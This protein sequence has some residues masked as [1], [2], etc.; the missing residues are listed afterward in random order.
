MVKELTAKEVMDLKIGSMVS[1][2]WTDSEHYEK[3]ETY[4]GPIFG[5]KSAIAE[6]ILLGKCVAFADDGCLDGNCGEYVKLLSEGPFPYIIIDNKKAYKAEKEK[7]ESLCFGQEA[8]AVWEAEGKEGYRMAKKCIAMDGGYLISRDG[9]K[10][11]YSS[12]GVCLYLPVEKMETEWYLSPEDAERMGVC[13]DS[14]TK[15]VIPKAP[16]SI[17]PITARDRKHYWQ[18]VEEACDVDEA[19]EYGDGAPMLMLF[20]S[21]TGKP[22]YVEHVPA[23]KSEYYPQRV[24]INQEIEKIEHK[25]AHGKPNKPKGGIPDIESAFRGHGMTGDSFVELIFQETKNAEDRLN[26]LNAIGSDCYRAEVM[27][28]AESC[29]HALFHALEK[30]NLVY[31]YKYWI[32]RQESHGK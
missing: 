14:T 31:D 18:Y 3:G 16:L 2:A 27:A 28:D 10:L 20:E 25:L 32:K 24:N 1:I 4:F 11:S 29:Y 8:Y 9:E 6:C 12:P 13:I 30:A 19:S 21:S 17:Y 15:F 22:V 23:L 26:A 7:V 5:G